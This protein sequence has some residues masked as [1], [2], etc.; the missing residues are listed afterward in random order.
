MPHDH[1]HEEDTHAEAVRRNFQ[2]LN[3]RD[4]VL[5]EVSQP[6]HGVGM[7]VWEAVKTDKH[8]VIMS[9]NGSKISD[10]ILG[11]ADAKIGYNDM[12]DLKEKLA[13]VFQK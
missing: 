3:D 10:M 2:L 13:G 7:E 9:K 4:A 1:V 11:V 12:N 6:S 5:A 8:V